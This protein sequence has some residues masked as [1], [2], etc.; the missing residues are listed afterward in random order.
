[1]QCDIRIK[2]PTYPIQDLIIKHDASDTILSLKRKIKAQLLNETLIESAQKLI[3]AGHVLEDVKTLSELNVRLNCVCAN[4]EIPI[5]AT[6]H[7]VTAPNIRP[8]TPIEPQILADPIQ[9]TSEPTCISTP[10]VQDT[11]PEIPTQPDVGLTEPAIDT[12]IPEIT[13]NDL[14]QVMGPNANVQATNIQYNVYMIDGYP[15]LIRGP[16][17]RSSRRRQERALVPTQSPATTSSITAVSAGAQIR[18][19]HVDLPATA[20]IPV[21]TADGQRALILS[22]EGVRAMA[23]QG[24]N[25]NRN[26]VRADSFLGIRASTIRNFMRTGIPH[27]WLFLKLTFLVVLLGSNSSWKRLIVLNIAAFLIFFWQSG[28]FMH[29]W[30]NWRRPVGPAVNVAADARVR[31]T[32]RDETAS[33]GGI[34]GAQQRPNSAVL[35]NLGRAFFSSII[36]GV[37]QPTTPVIAQAA[38]PAVADNPAGV[39]PIEQTEEQRNQEAED[40]ATPSQSIPAHDNTHEEE[41][42]G[43]RDEQPQETRQSQTSD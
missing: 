43:Q 34:N 20:A 31:D 28:I 6:F 29:M 23:A 35:Q 10:E 17:K 30:G 24:V 37:S 5:A 41:V 2:S 16:D 39:G 4:R 19:H 3:Y 38:F 42:S 9:S 13:A 21:R 11:Q 22:P 14:P 27:S 32:G 40:Q 26:I 12:S 25:V 15:Y 33:A 7:L 36:P 8:I 1:M 18:Q